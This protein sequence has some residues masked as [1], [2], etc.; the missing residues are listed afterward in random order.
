[1]SQTAGSTARRVESVARSEIEWRV[2]HVGGS[3]PP[4]GAA[5][6]AAMAPVAVTPPTAQSIGPQR[7]T[8]PAIWGCASELDRDNILNVCRW[9]NKRFPDQQNIPSCPQRRP[10]RYLTSVAGMVPSGSSDASLEHTLKYYTSPVTRTL[11]N[12]GTIPFG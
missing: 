2:P 10:Q 6:L 4:E 12:E 9:G 1:M 8:L 11:S 7:R 5:D 3:T